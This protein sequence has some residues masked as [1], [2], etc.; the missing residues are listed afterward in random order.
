MLYPSELRGHIAINSLKTGV[1]SH[2]ASDQM[3]ASAQL[4]G[5]IG[6]DSKKRRIQSEGL[7]MGFIRFASDGL[8]R[9][10]QG[11]TLTN[12]FTVASNMQ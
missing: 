12:L 7:E 6:L 10:I 11:E 2:S 5:R 4:C 8:V 9:R 3:L 1:K